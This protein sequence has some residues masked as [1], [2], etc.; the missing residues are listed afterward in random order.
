MP[1]YSENEERETFDVCLLSMPFPPLNQPSMALGLLKATLLDAGISVK[2]LYPCIWFAEEVGLDVYVFISDSKQEFFAG[3]WTFA[4]V[5]FPE[6][7]PDH[8]A[9][10]DEVFSAPVSRGL[11][12]RSR[13]G[14]DPR[15]ALRKAREAAPEFIESVARR[16]LANN[17]KIVGCTSTFMQHCASLAILRKIRE[18][19]PNVVTVIGGANCEGHMG[20]AAKRF[21]P[22]LDFVVSGEGELL[23]PQLCRQILA[24]GKEIPA[25][26]LPAGVIGSD[27]ARLPPG[28]EAP[29]AS[30]NDMN[31]S[32]VPDFDDYFEALEASPLRAFISPGL[33][34]E[35]S[36]GCWWGKVH[37]CTFCGLNG[38]NMTFRSKSPER[39]LA[40]LD[41]LSQRY[42][43][44][45]FNIVDNIL[46]LAYIQTLLPRLAMSEPYTLFFE[47]KS[48]LKREQLEKIADAGIRR[49]QPG[50]ENMHDEVLRLI[51]K[52]T[53]AL[54]N[55]RLLKWAREI[56]VFITW[57]FLWDVPGEKDEWYGEMAEW[58]RLVSHLQPPGVD[59]IQFHRFSPYHQRP[60]SFGLSL[61]P[62]PLYSYVY[63]L[64][65]ADM[66]ELAYYFHDSERQPARLELERRPHL[67]SVMKIIAV[68]NKLWGQGGTKTEEEAPVLLMRE[69]SDGLLI[70]DT[71]P[72][73]V[74]KTHRLRAQASRI[75]RACDEIHTVNS[76]VNAL[77][78]DRQGDVPAQ[79]VQ[80][81]LDE[82]EE[83]KLLLH[84]NG[85]YLALA[86]R[87]VRRIPDTLEEFPGGYTDIEAWQAHYAN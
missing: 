14:S 19:A 68:W 44:R 76:L 30:I 50:I 39:V 24:Q 70:T 38:G 56:G 8:E 42:G 54:L 78:K 57:N 46:D 87:E 25:A 59:R 16:V 10:L 36:R 58:L 5:A 35:T 17:P 37:H 77:A 13:F 23:F 52:G 86:L 7:E 40:E 47:T 72:C 41:G 45:K 75:Y 33:A 21:F 82:L 28:A 2:N 49:L 3:E 65:P 66:R 31:T 63:P 34:M 85:R 74:S 9:Y 62:F 15:N 73:A 26:E 48:N 60:E 43:I 27:Q 81:V 11:L 64:P 71:R 67:K 1:D 80:R 20:L 53:T 18:I 51:D 83:R 84:L 32:P 55:V 6:F 4:G 79:T 12:R 61:I 29:R 69:E 22:W